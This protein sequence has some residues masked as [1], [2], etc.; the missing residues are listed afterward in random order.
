[1][2]IKDILGLGKVLPI[3][4]LIDIVSNSVGK[5][6]KAYFDRKDVDTKAYEIKKL[7]EARAEEMKIMSS[8]IR[9]NFHLTGGIE[10]KEERLQISSPS[11]E[12]RTQER[13]SFQE[14]KKQLNIESITAV[15]AEELKNEPPITNEPLD[16]DWTTRFFKIAE[17]ISNE[18]MQNLWGK[19]LAGEVKRPKSYSLRTLELIRNLS[20]HEAQ[21]FMKLAN[22]AINSGRTNF[23]CKDNK[24]L[25]NIEYEEI[26]LMVEIGLIQPGEFL[27]F[28]LLPSDIDSQ[29]V[30]TSGNK[31]VI[32]KIK[33]NTPMIEIPVQVF[34]NSANELLKLINTNPP[35]EYLTS[36]AKTIR[37][38]HVEIKYGSILEW[39]ENGSIRHTQPLQEFPE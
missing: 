20:S 34:S 13:T 15:A 35:F 30:F 23:I 18:E 4:K 14:A 19:I 33:A 6:S 8:A 21:V 36:F 12:E 29:I 11:I 26:A 5:I 37:R 24:S 10:Y 16:E 17:E 3:D 32:A 31:I 39:L 9:E 27:N 2:E 7:A 28:Q 38:E 25:F 22:F 1:M